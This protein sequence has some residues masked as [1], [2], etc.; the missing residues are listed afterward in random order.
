[1]NVYTTSEAREHF[2]EI[3]NKV[4]FGKRRQI[5]SRRGKNL[6]AVIPVEDLEL[7]EELEDRQDLEMARE[8]LKNLDI[9][10]T[11]PLSVIKKELG[12]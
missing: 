6:V 4:A 1:M 11:K 9:K 10:K 2:S 3:I 8:E 5:L 7:L 12:L